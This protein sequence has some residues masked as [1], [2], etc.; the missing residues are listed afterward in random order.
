MEKLH[1]KVDPLS[2]DVLGQGG[3]GIVEDDLLEIFPSDLVRSEFCSVKLQ[4]DN[5]RTEE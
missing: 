2:E 5:R 4:V 3:D 1:L